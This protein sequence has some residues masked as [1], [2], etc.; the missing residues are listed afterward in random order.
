[1][2]IEKYWIFP[3]ILLL[4]FCSNY[5]PLFNRVCTSLVFLLVSGTI[6][7]IRTEWIGSADVCFFTFFG[8]YLGMERMLV[9]LYI[10]VL[11]GFLWIVYKK[12][13]ILPYLSCLS[14]G[15]WIAYLK[16]YTIFYF[17]I[18]LFSWGQVISMSL[19][20]IWWLWSKSPVLSILLPPYK[21]SFK[22]G[23]FKEAHW[24]RIWCFLPVRIVTWISE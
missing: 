17:L 22:M 6:K 5:V 10:S 19:N 23:C 12:K 21:E 1:M 8:F 18:N 3:S 2:Y 15:V 13:H 4:C 24:T 16:G 11:L 14:I 20:W 7:I 9:A